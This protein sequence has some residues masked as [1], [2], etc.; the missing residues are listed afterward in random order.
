KYLLTLGYFAVIVI[1]L[2]YTI[3]RRRSLKK[4]IPSGLLFLILTSLAVY[5]YYNSNKNEDEASKKFLGDYK[6]E[7]LDGKVCDSCKVR[8]NNGYTYD[9]IVKNNKVGE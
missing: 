2:I 3:K 6:L 8:L 4:S 1:L 5:A 9:I 7:R